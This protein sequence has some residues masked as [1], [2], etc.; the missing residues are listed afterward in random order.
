MHKIAATNNETRSGLKPDLCTLCERRTSHPSC[1][2]RT[3]TGELL[4]SRVV[5]HRYR[6]GQVIFCA[7]MPLQALHVVRSGRVKI[8]RTELRG[9]EQVI[10]LLGPGEIFGYRPLLAGEPAAASAEA[11]EDC[12]IC[13]L[14]AQAVPE[15]LRQSPELSHYLMTKLAR[16]LRTSEDLLMDLLHRPVRRRAAR[17][18][19][20]LFN[21]TR[22]ARDHGTLR[23]SHLKRQDMARMIGTTPETLSRVLRGFA[24]RGAVE[25]GRTHI[26]IL[27]EDLLVKLAGDLPPRA[28]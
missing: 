21:D 26:R 9:E 18:L 11:V 10:R 3:W 17:L 28:T 23:S 8:S 27:R 2:L 12:T 15:L 5:V 14:S 16:E 6:R 24:R 1:I 22:G 19:L 20:S 4:E 7:G 25:L 13:L